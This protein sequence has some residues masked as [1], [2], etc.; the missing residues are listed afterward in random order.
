M[1]LFNILPQLLL[2]LVVLA[3]PAPIE[4]EPSHQAVVLSR[5]FTIR[6]HAIS[7]AQSA[8]DNLYLEPY[9]IYPTFNYATLYPKTDRTPGIV[10]FLNGTR[11]ELKYDQGNL[12]FLGGG[13]VYGFI[14]DTVNATY[15]PMEINVG[16]GTKG[17]YI[18][19]GVIKYNNPISGG[20]Y[21]ELPFLFILSR[22]IEIILRLAKMGANRTLLYGDAVQLF[23]RPKTTS[24]PY[25]CADVEL[26]VDY[27]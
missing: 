5:N 2:P 21:G 10:G 26:V 19:Q 13:G 7:R 11:N 20:F 16:T 1:H 9:H 25:G 6:S 23:Y 17:I 27:V 22:S 4:N 18:G 14:I 3:V 15:N 24:A 8:F 12:L